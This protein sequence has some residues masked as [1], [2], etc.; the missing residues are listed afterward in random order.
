MPTREY[1][2]MLFQKAEDA[3]QRAK[4]AAEPELKA[5]W[6]RIEASYRTM[7]TSPSEQ[8]PR[9]I[10]AGVSLGGGTANSTGE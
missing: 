5:A 10:F 3:A 4:S 8:P 1:Q 9:P 2:Q 7:A 6:E